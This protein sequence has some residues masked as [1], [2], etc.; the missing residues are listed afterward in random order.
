MNSAYP[1]MAVPLSAAVSM[2]PHRSLLRG[3]YETAAL[4]GTATKAQW[5]RRAQRAVGHIG[6]SMGPFRG[7]AV[8]GSAEPDI[9]LAT[10]ILKRILPDA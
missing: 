2:S 10:K 7:Y 8:A 6:Q 4:S 3:L 1:P 5:Y 9:S